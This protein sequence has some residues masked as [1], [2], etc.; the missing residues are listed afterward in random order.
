ME[1]LSISTQ[2]RDQRGKE[3]AKKLRKRGSVPGI[4]Y[5]SRGEPVALS[6]NMSELIKVLST[7]MGENILLDI[8]IKVNETTDIRTAL[9]KDIQYHPV[10]DQILHVDF[11]E[12][13]MDEEITISVPVHVKGIPI[14]V[15]EKDGVLEHLKREIEIRCLPTQ[16]PEYIEVD[17]EHLDIGH[18]VHIRDIKVPGGITIIEDEDTAV[19]GVMAPELVVEEEK[20]EVEPEE[21]EA[22]EAEEKEE[23]DKKE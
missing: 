21:E 13:P 2:I 18:S 16:I 12:I 14:G 7:H 20:E 9:I 8:N 15:R 22:K 6:L 23:K 1:R 4:L 10:K 17:V 11:F 5:S 19:L 3:Y